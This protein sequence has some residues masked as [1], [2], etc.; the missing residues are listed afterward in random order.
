MKRQYAV[1]LVFLLVCV[2]RSEA[3]VTPRHVG[4][5]SMDK[6]TREL[7][8]ESMDLDAQLYDEGVKLVHRP[9]YRSRASGTGSYMVRESSWYAL[10]L[11]L[12]DAAGDRQRAAEIL[13]AVLKQQYLTPGVKWYG[14]YRRTPEEPDPTGNPVIWRVHDSHSR[15][16][17]WPHFLM[18]LI[19]YARPSSPEISKTLAVTIHCTPYSEV[20]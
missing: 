9:G 12:R 3:Y 2:A 8:Q 19:P 4:L 16:F 5:A 14:T 11:L 17:Y 7:F 6:N 20:T 1:G 18:I 15:L 10:G 13:D